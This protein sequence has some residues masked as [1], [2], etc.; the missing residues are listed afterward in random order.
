MGFLLVVLDVAGCGSVLL[1]ATFAVLT[2]YN[3]ASQNRNQPHPTLSA[4]SPYAVTRDLST[5]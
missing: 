2:P 1:A 4:K 5:L 3:V